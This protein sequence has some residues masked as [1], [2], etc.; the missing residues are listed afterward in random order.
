MKVQYPLHLGKSWS[1]ASRVPS[2]SLGEEIFGACVCF[3]LLS[4][5]PIG[6]SR[7]YAWSQALGSILTLTQA[8]L[9]GSHFSSFL[10]LKKK[11]VC[12]SLESESSTA[13]NSLLL[14]QEGVNAG[15]WDLADTPLL[16]E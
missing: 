10:D 14:L 11:S 9:P 6:A 5:W 1:G 8:M 2:C 15:Q 13:H 7:G 16:R 12:T 4:I 3:L